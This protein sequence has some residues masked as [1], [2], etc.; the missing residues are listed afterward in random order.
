MS[1]GPE[2]EPPREP[3]ADPSGAAAKPAEAA[4][5]PEKRASKPDPTE[6]GDDEWDT[7]AEPGGLEDEGEPDDEGPDA[8][9]ETDA[10]SSP[11]AA[12]PPLKEEEP[13]PDSTPALAGDSMWGSASRSIALGACIGFA[14]GAWA[15]LALLG[16]E[17]NDLLAKN[18]LELGERV[19]AI[20]TCIAAAALGAGAAGYFV[21]AA[22]RAK[23]NVGL[24]ERWL[25]FS[26]PLMLAPGLASVLHY[27][28]W[29]NA[30]DRLLPVVLL[31]SLA[32]EILAFQALVAAPR[33]AREWWRDVIAQIPKIARERGPLILVSAAT[34][35]YIGFFS[36][37]LVRWHYKLKTGNFDLSINNNLLFGGLRGHFL[38][39]TVVFPQ[40]PKK[41]LANHAKFGG[42]LFLPI[43]ALF[44]RAE[45]L[46][47]LQSTLIGASAMPLFGFARRRL[48]EWL[49]ALVALAYLAYYPMHGASF[50]EFQ[51]VPIAGFF[52]LS[53]IWAAETRRWVVFW[54]VFLMGMTMR[55][56]IPIGMALVGGFLLLSG[57]RPL[58]GLV[59]AVI[60]VIY[61]VTLR[62]YVMDSAGDWWFPNMY[63]ELWADGEKGFRS[64]IK[65]LL[66][67]PL[68]VISKVLV[69]KKLIY[70]LHLLVPLAFLPARRWYLWSA[71]IPGAFLTLL[72]TNY[73]P[74]ITFTFHYVMHWAPYLF[75]AA[76]L[77]LE[78]IGKRP[79]F[80]LERRHAAAL[81]MG[82]ASLVLSYNYGAF[83][84]RDG[85]FKGGFQKVD[86][87][88]TDEERARYQNLRTLIALIPPDA[89]VAAT[90][91]VGPHA[92]SRLLMYTMRHGSQNAEYILASSRELKLSRTKPKLLEAL[93]S[94]EYGVVKRI[95]DLALLKKGQ[96]PSHN[97]EMVRDWKL[98]DARQP[99]P[100]APAINP[101][102]RPRDGSPLREMGEPEPRAPEEEAGGE[103]R[104]PE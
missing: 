92:S 23:R 14:L 47:V 75:V 33:Q 64:V 71:F 85:S 96:D 65:T 79:D 51:Y 68:F 35:F 87:E 95:A 53:A 82:G 88:M 10:A 89:S 37:Y 101:P 86:F 69:E 77:A 2:R 29:L 56:D 43:Y 49:A 57:H 94:N 80:G 63:K 104:P 25:W 97:E 4:T 72:V 39:S 103:P 73:D 54:I 18:T 67:N 93:R 76:V 91:K 90:E 13:V 11:L 50:S 48:P 46:L 15:Q 21:W 31:L 42:Y 45:T 41:Y 9:S 6:N 8:T 36:F 62:F 60:S 3:V 44:P 17:A 61:F 78:A 98:V 30:Y 66:S 26:S 38:E 81:A 19:G 83:P 34:L 20:K 84:R 100:P 52:V 12:T 16:R 24:V 7:E 22:L 5:E 28:P 40:D 70:L 59:M 99:P 74:P 1:E 102:A 32:F 58:P 27:K 55:E